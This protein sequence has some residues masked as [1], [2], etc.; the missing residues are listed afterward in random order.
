MAGWEGPAPLVQ[1]ISDLG[2]IECQR[3][4][5]QCRGPSGPPVGFSPGPNTGF[6]KKTE[7]TLLG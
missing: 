2:G 7:A 5:G 3:E 6:E 4:S 1:L